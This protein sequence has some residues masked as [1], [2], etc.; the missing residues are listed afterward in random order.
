MKNELLMKTFSTI[1]PEF[2]YFF[3]IIF[4]RNIITT[5]SKFNFKFNLQINTYYWIWEET[6]HNPY[7]N[8]VENLFLQ[9]ICGSLK[10]TSASLIV[11]GA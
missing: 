5:A 2:D 1:L 7:K 10:A 3:T 6:L 9:I 11:K 8:F 4:V